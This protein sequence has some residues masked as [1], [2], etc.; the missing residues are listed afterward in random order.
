M[1]GSH[2]S[3]C[4][5]KIPKTNIA[6]AMTLARTLA[7]TPTNSFE[8]TCD[9]CRSQFMDVLLLC[10][11][12]FYKSNIRNYIEDTWHVHIASRNGS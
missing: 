6:H 7:V 3:V 11:A 5:S 12:P 10:V 9:P 4:I 8:P 2:W 1:Q